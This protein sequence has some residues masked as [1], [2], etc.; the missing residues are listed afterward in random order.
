MSLGPRIVIASP[1][2]TEVEQLS[3]WLRAEAIEPVPAASL[4]AAIDLA[5]STPF[6]VLVA[7]AAFA[8][9][10]RLHAVARTCN[11]RAP[12]VVVG[13]HDAALLADRCGAYH[14]E[15][16]VDQALL[17]CIVTMA[18][19]DGR[20]A[21]RSPRKRIPRFD[22]IVDGTEGFVID[23]SNEGL[24]FEFP[25]RFAPAP[26]FGIRIPLVGIALTV[27]RVWVAA[28]ATEQGAGS[29]CGVELYEAHPRAEENWRAFVSTVPSA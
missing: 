2:R 5:E 9:E 26:Q 1:D 7:D 8:F 16:P 6:D 13:G 25:R 27:R 29:C 14:L 21:R 3:D 23:V 15:R 24:R 22:A 20:P 12:M 11:P 18:I 10:G 4:A 19:L 28:P 17:L